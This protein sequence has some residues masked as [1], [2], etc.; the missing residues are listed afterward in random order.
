MDR[1]AQFP[2]YGVLKASKGQSKATKM[3][4]GAMLYMSVAKELV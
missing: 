4:G 3:G 1:V 2:R